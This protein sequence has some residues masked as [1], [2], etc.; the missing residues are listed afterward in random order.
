MCT[1]LPQNEESPRNSDQKDWKVLA[2]NP[3]KW[4]NFGGSLKLDCYVN[5]DFM[6]CL[7]GGELKMNKILF[8]SAKSR[9]SYVITLSGAPVLWVSKLQT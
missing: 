6:G 2:G 9:T 8:A 3:E 5:T 7:S 1:F 4:P